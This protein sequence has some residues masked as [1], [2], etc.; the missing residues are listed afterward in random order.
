MIS[1]KQNYNI[2][3]IKDGFQLLLKLSAEST[4]V[5]AHAISIVRGQNDPI[6]AIY[7]WV[8]SNLKYVPDPSGPDYSIEMFTSPVKQI[9][10]FNEGKE[11]SEDC[12]GHAL[13]TTALYKA[14]GIPSNILIIDSVGEGFDHAY[15][16]VWSSALGMYVSADTTAKFPFGWIIPAK[17]TI[18]IS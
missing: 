14:I 4:L 7:N 15:S 9:E 6:S 17:Q 5:R 13:L 2:Q 11:I 1:R 10:W 16:E 3:D 12:D 18:V 8:K